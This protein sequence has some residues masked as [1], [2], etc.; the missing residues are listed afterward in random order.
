MAP[1]VASLGVNRDRMREAAAEGHITATAVADALVEEGVPFR[2]AH[3]AVGRLVAAAELRG[4]PLDELTDSAVS[5]SLAAS[6][7]EAA[8]A[9]AE[10]PGIGER[11]RSAAALD[12]AMARCDVVGGTAPGRVRAELEAAATR[13]GLTVAAAP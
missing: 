13:L 3:H 1:L 8:R 10:D 12:G 11:V 7:D 9:L 6:D 5:A 2:D 4:V